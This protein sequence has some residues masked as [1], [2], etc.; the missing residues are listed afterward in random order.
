MAEIS[1][2]KLCEGLSSNSCV[3]FEWTRI[4]KYHHVEE[5]CEALQGN[6][7]CEELIL[8]NCGVGNESA[9]L[10]AEILK[11]NTT[12]KKI[13]LGYNNIDGD[14]VAAMAAALT[15]NA[16]LTEVKLHRQ[17]GDMGPKME[18]ELTAVWHTNI[19]LTRL[20]CTLHSRKFNGDNTRGEIRNKEISR[21]K[22]AGRDW[23]DLD[24]A[25]VDEYRAQQEAKR[26]EEAEAAAAA[27][28]PISAKIASTGGPYTYKQLTSAR[29]F[30]P[31][32]VEI[33]IRETYLSDA[34]FA[35]VMGM[36][37]EAFGKLAGWKTKG[38]KKEKS[39]N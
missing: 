26:T 29:E 21:R 9:K 17:E 2:T 24:P 8:Q 30:W 38:L 16:T 20:Y 7:S 6:T 19:T 27:N 13:D 3:N 1:L 35:T 28:A 5:I 15:V 23:L 14:G 37:R 33:G 10:I 4:L 31:D 25:R 36:D 11:T 32:D 34:E 39:L 12:M 22:E 18:E